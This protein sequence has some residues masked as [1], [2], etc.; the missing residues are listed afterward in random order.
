MH[1]VSATKVV[2]IRTAVR[3]T[4]DW[5]FILKQLENDSRCVDKSALIPVDCLNLFSRHLYVVSVERGNSHRTT[6]RL[7][8]INQE[9][10]A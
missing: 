5:I 7:P 8:I 3:N 6:R 2:I 9:I 10:L 1:T 4:T